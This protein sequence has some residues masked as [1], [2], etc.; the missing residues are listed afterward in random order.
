MKT[1][2]IHINGNYKIQIS[3]EAEVKFKMINKDEE[4]K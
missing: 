3:S 4:K 1:Y 2:E